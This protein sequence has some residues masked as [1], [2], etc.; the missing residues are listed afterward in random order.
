MRRNCHRWSNPRYF[1]C[2]AN[3]DS[4]VR[5]KT[6]T[7]EPCRLVQP[8]C[9]TARPRVF[10][11]LRAAKCVRPRQRT[12]EPRSGPSHL[13]FR[14]PQPSRWAS[15][16]SAPELQVSATP[17]SRNRSRASGV[18]TAC[19]PTTTVRSPFQ[20]RRRSASVRTRAVQVRTDVLSSDVAPARSINHTLPAPSSA[21][22]SFEH[23]RVSGR[24]PRRLKS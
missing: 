7:P 9:D 3:T 22:V 15:S 1:C 5:A 10:L 20:S 13:G 23:S 21:Q 4:R 8:G 24:R 14:Q 2:D 19:R 12:P 11:V 18:T 6:M 17:H 16:C